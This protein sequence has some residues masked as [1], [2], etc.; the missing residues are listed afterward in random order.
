MLDFFFCEKLKLSLFCISVPQERSKERISAMFAALQLHPCSLVSVLM[1]KD[2]SAFKKG[3]RRSFFFS[4][5]RKQQWGK[6]KLEIKRKN[7]RMPGG[8][9]CSRE[10]LGQGTHGQRHR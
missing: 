4:Q 7:L 3:L 5:R 2:H 8:L 6:K 1:A 10:A 9:C